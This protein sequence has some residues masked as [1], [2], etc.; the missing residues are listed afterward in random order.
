MTGWTQ[1]VLTAGH[2]TQAIAAW[3]EVA[4]APNWYLGPSI[5]AN[6]P[7][8]DFGLIRNDGGNPQPGA[9]KLW[10]GTFQPISTWW[11][12]YPGLWICKSGY[13]TTVTCGVVQAINVTVF[14]PAGP[15]YGL[16]QTNACARQ[17]DSG[18]PLFAGD[19]ALGLASAADLTASG[20][21]LS[22]PRSFFQPVGEALNAYGLG[23]ITQ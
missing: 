2:C 9:V 11:E 18:G 12:A 8:D 3:D 22:P 13:R 1:G 20:E 17:G 19:L 15:V 14:V 6:F 23:L 7:Y 5:F 4:D 16:V 21:C 10:N